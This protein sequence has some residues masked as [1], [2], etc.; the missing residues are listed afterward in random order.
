[1]I[2]EDRRYIAVPGEH[3]QIGYFVVENRML[4]AQLGPKG[5]GAGAVLVAMQ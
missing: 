5:F 1:M 3:P 4:I 2:G